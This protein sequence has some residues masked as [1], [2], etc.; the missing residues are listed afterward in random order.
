M[1]LRPPLSWWLALSLIVR[2]GFVGDGLRCFLSCDL[3]PFMTRVVFLGCCFRICELPLV[4]PAIVSITSASALGASGK[5]QFLDDVRAG[6]NVP[7]GH[8]VAF[9][10]AVWDHEIGIMPSAVHHFVL[11]TIQ[12]TPLV[13]VEHLECPALVHFAGM[14]EEVPAEFRVHATFRDL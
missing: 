7:L 2:A 13:N 8:A 1:Q 14:P 10:F 4:R 6:S 3:H 12:K 9:E 5:S 11:Q